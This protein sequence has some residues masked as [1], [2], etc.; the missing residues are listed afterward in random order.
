M[1]TAEQMR[2]LAQKAN[3]GDNCNKKLLNGILSGIEKAAKKGVF[4]ATIDLY[5]NDSEQEIC[6][7]IIAKL[8]DLGYK[9]SSKY[10]SA[11]SI[12]GREDEACRT[13]KIFW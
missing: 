1:K 8:K 5:G 11:P 3:R 2:E 7:P 12:V 9:V 4:F 6:Q 10:T 13:I